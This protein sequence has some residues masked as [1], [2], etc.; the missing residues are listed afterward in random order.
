VGQE[1]LDEVK[2][3]QEEFSDLAKERTFRNKLDM[4]FLKDRDKLAS[5]E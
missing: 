4:K 5:P 3:L 1:E 2:K